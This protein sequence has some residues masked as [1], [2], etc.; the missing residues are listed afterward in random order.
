MDQDLELTAPSKGTLFCSG[1]C[2]PISTEDIGFQIKTSINSNGTYSSNDMPLLSESKP[3]RND[4]LKHRIDKSAKENE[5]LKCTRL[6]AGNTGDCKAN[7][8]ELKLSVGPQE[9]LTRDTNRSEYSDK[10]P[11]PRSK[12]IPTTFV[13]VT[14]KFHIQSTPGDCMYGYSS[15]IHC[16][17]FLRPFFGLW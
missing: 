10:K 8:D 12:D 17:S 11:A 1:F 9:T 16:F 2:E 4:T 14:N 13:D 5:F 3:F 6:E 7:C 15:Q